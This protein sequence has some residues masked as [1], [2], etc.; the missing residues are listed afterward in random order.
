MK[1]TLIIIFLA[2]IASAA[3]GQADRHLLREG[4]RNY[5]KDKFDQSEINYRRAL[6]N[7]SNDFRGQYNLGNSLY[8]QKKYDEA[9]RHYEQALANPDLDAHKRARTLHNQGNSL[10]KAGLENE[11]Q[12]MQYFQQAVKSYQESL[13][14]EPKDEDTR[15]NLAYAR[16]L[17]QQAQQQQQ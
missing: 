16:R 15:Y 11:Q 6:E 5:K 13:K 3:Y 9:A 17:L 12:G 14:L 10:V 7:D 1:K 8:R 2:I 4:N